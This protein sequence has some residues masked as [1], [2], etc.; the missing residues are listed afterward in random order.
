MTDEIKV[1]CIDCIRLPICISKDIDTLIL[2]CE[3]V[4]DYIVREQVMT[5]NAVNYTAKD[6]R[7]V[8]LYPKAISFD[9]DSINNIKVYFR[10]FKRK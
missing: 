10:S 3:E 9:K 6:G 2:N 5:Y 7:P 1:P 4:Y 8:C